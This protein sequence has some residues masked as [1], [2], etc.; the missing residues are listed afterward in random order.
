MNDVNQYN[1]GVIFAKDDEVAHYFFKRWHE[2][3]ITSKERSN[4]RDQPSLLLT[5][6]EMP[7]VVEPL[8]GIWN[9]QIMISIAYLHRAKI[10]H[11]FNT[12]WKKTNISPFFGN[13]FYLRIK[14]EGKL[15]EEMK[16]VILNCK[17][18]FITPSMPVTMSEVQLGRTP[19]YNLLL[20]LYME[21][22]DTYNRIEKYIC[23]ILRKKNKIQAWFTPKVTNKKDRN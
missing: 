6:D 2:N 7:N 16:N 11:F 4:N 14:E 21:K 10:M 3:W 20:K 13:N 12:Q 5:C 22:S 18:E 9:C 15:T 8:S 17:S 19:L 23:S 1:S